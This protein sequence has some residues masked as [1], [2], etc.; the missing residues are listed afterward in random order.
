MAVV[1]NY[2]PSGTIE[3]KKLAVALP[4]AI[5]V[6]GVAG[7]L[8]AVLGH[9]NLLAYIPISILFISVGDIGMILFLLASLFG[10]FVAGTWVTQ[11]AHNR[12]PTLALPLGIGIGLSSLYFHWMTLGL[13]AG[14]VFVLPHEVIAMQNSMVRQ[15]WTSWGLFD[16]PGSSWF[17]WSVEAIG[18]IG[19]ATFGAFSAAKDPFCESCQAWASAEEIVDFP[20]AVDPTRLAARLQS[21]EIA[22]LDAFVPQNDPLA[23]FHRYRFTLKNCAGCNG[24]NVLSVEEVTLTYDEDGE[25]SE[26][27]DDVVMGLMLSV[28]SIGELRAVFAGP[29]PPAPLEQDE[30]GVNVVTL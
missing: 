23:S 14:D 18:F 9:W 6:G 27:L 28:E 30:S 25:V 12:N 21:G 16:S 13:L 19:A 8:Y 5:V 1:E 11:F 29:Q 20:F 4:V 3:W 17:F 10:V 7:A 2:T 24:L 15:G 26:S 22:S